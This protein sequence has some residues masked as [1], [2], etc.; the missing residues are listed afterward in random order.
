MSAA[1]SSRVRGAVSARVRML[2]ALLP[3]VLLLGACMEPQRRVEVGERV[4]QFAAPT[5][6]GEQLGLRELRGEVV[7]LNVWAT[8]CYPCRR[9]MPGLEALH[10]EL[11]DAGL[12]VVAVSVDAAGAAGDIREFLDELGLTMLVLHDSRAEVS[13][14]FST[15]GVPETFLIGSDGTL[16]RHWIGRI[17]AHSESVRRPVLDALAERQRRRS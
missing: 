1:R 13:R 15:I 10:R 12:R 8:W 3:A 5:L 16:V 11:S 17:D 9:E 2:A 7:L 14:A 6:E 4:P